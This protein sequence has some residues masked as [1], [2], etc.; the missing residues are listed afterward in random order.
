MIEIEIE[1]DSPNT[2][3]IQV[4][5]LTVRSIIARIT[6][7][8]LVLTLVKNFFVAHISVYC[9]YRKPGTEPI[10]CPLFFKLDCIW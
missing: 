3:Y 7:G 2:A 10:L 1:I 8:S 4:I 5:N 6:T 9:A